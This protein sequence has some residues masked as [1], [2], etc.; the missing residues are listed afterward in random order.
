[1]MLDH[2]KRDEIMHSVLNYDPGKFFQVARSLK[3]PRNDQIKKLLVDNCIYEDDNVCDGFYGSILHLK[4]RAHEDLQSNAIF[5]SANEEY[6][7]ILKICQQ[8]AKIP[9]IS[10]EMTRQ[11][12]YSIRPTV[13]DHASITAYHYRYAGSAG[14]AHLHGLI[15]AIITDMNNMAVEELTIVSACILHKGHGKNKNQS[16]S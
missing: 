12:L 6:L 9:A 4:T 15:N 16:V 3:C 13:S 7:N 2:I 8:G 1:M 11:I 10:V 5:I 14:L